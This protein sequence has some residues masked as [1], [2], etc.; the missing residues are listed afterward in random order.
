V[1]LILTERGATKV[2]GKIS[3]IDLAGSERG[4]DTWVSSGSYSTES[5]CFFKAPCVMLKCSALS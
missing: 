3:F 1:Q 2:H 5:F 4:A